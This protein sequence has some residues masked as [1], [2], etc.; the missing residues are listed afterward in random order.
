VAGK[1]ANDLPRQG[2]RSAQGSFGNPKERGI[3]AILKL[4]FGCEIASRA[5]VAL[6]GAKVEV[7]GECVNLNDCVQS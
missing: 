6:V 2:Y 3:S 1:G 5:G 7:C 4:G